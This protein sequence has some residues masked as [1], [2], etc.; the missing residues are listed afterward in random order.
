MCTMSGLPRIIGFQASS[1]HTEML[2]EEG[3]GSSVPISWLL[4]KNLSL[5]GPHK[6]SFERKFCTYK[7][8]LKTPGLREKQAIPELSF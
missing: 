6:L 2:G 8:K 3:R 1:G 7:G 5:S 4:Q